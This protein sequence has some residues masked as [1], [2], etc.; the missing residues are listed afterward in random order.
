MSK[1]LEFTIFLLLL[2][3]FSNFISSRLVCKC[4]WDPLEF[5]S[6]TEKTSKKDTWKDCVI[7]YI[8][9]FVRYV[10][11][12]QTVLTWRKLLHQI[13]PFFWNLFPVIVGSNRIRQKSK[14]NPAIRKW[15]IPV[16][17][18]PIIPISNIVLTVFC[19]SGHFW[20]TASIKE[21]KK[22]YI[23]EGNDAKT[24]SHMLRWTKDRKYL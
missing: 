19:I 18:L 9:Y 4:K 24:V 23:L 17:F 7:L 22:K 2:N 21:N 16:Q 20:Y 14:V 1:N 15:K 10:R 12:T 6:P 11:Y 5:V 3:I 13:S 8:K